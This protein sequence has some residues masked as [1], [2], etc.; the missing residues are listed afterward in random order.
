MH[1][2]IKFKQNVLKMEKKIKIKFKDKSELLLN[3]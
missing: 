3:I 2:N 1:N